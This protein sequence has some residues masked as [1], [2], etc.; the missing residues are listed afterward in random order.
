MLG[1]SSLDRRRRARQR[2]SKS[3]ACRRDPDTRNNNTSYLCDRPSG[4]KDV[5]GYIHC[6]WRTKDD[7]MINAHPHTVT[8]GHQQAFSILDKRAANNA[9][10]RKR[11]GHTLVF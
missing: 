8:H 1:P 11:K 5:G 2:R 9:G 6:V 4:D 7:G 10:E 3:W